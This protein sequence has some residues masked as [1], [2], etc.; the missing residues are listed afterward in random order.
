[1]PIKVS[2]PISMQDIVDEFGGDAPHNLDEYYRGGSRVPNANINV[3]VPTSGAIAVGNFY[4]ASKIIYFTAEMFGGGGAGGNGYENGGDP[5][6]RPGDGQPTGILLKS[7]FDNGVFNFIT[8][9]SGG[10]AGLHG[11]LGA[12]AGGSG[13][14]GSFGTGGNAGGALNT[15]APAADFSKFGSGG[16]GGGGDQG[17]AGGSFFGIISYGGG[18]NAGKAGAGGSAGSTNLQTI[19]IDTGVE[20]VLMVGAGGGQQSGFGN[21]LGANGV[22]GYLRYKVST[23]GNTDEWTQVIEPLRVNNNAADYTMRRAYLFKLNDSGEPL[24]PQFIS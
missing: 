6:T 14:V 5:N 20:Y 17:S 13:A 22:P 11:T 16:G 8:S 18:D 4:G 12:T 3:N 7:D 9:A 24:A 1:M 2:G 23:D 21:H 19:E 10:N 15:A